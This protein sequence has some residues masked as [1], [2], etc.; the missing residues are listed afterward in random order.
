LYGLYEH[1]DHLSSLTITIVYGIYALGVVTSLLIAG[2]V[3]DWYGR[4]AVLLPALGLAIVAAVVFLA[5]R[6]LAG[7]LAARLLTG[8][9]LGAALATA[10]AFITD[11]GGGATRRASVVATVANLGGLGV[12][13]LLS[14]VLARYEPHALTLPFLAF[15][16]LL[17]LAV[18]LVVLAPEGHP[19]LHPRPAYRPQ[20]LSAPA[21]ARG[22]FAAAT[23]GAFA[24]FAVGGLFT[25]LTGTFL[26]GPLHHSSSALIGATIFLTY[27]G[28]VLAQT[29]T[30]G[31]PARRLVAF[32]IPVIFVGL[33]ILV[34]SAWTSPPSLTL[35]LIASFVAGA[36]IG[37]IIRGSLSVVISTSGPDDR[38]GALAAFFTAGYVGIALPAIAVGLVLQQLSPRVTLLIF[39]LVVGVGLLVAAPVLVR[40]ATAVAER[41]NRRSNSPMPLSRCFGADPQ[42]EET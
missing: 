26:A 38:A 32:G 42:P 2:H 41:S 40:P 29:T 3:S 39:G 20:R 23:T 37:A 15:L 7:L 18:A 33:V 10:T 22:E 4:R 25:G 16:G 13:P 34:A 30:T 14:G 17:V 8:L 21:N 31:W 24:A 19:A 5:S 11:L 35:F 36:G 28:A 9:A 12:G 6:S 27:A 1:R